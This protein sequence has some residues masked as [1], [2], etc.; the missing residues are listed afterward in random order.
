MRAAMAI[1]PLALALSHPASAHADGVQVTPVL[2][3]VDG[4]RGTASLRVRNLRER[5]ISFDVELYAWDQIDGADVLAPTTD[6][7]AAPSVFAIAPGQEQIL[8]IARAGASRAS[9]PETEIAYRL[10]LRELPSP[11]PSANGFRVQLTMSLP[12]FVVPRASHTQLAATRVIDPA[13]GPSIRLENAG[14]AHIRL[15]PIAFGPSG[16]RLDA[17]PRYLLA[18]RSITR[19]LGADIG[20]IEITYAGADTPAPLT[21]TL[22]LN[23]P[24][25]LH[26]VR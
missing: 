25:L 3:T 21:T 23:A 2:V 20:E 14:S 19:A 16:E 8:R 5:E 4:A 22:S 24:R 17:A 6:L 26:R 12:V 15:G 10:L 7:I 9:V 1:L 11:E 18:G 13:L